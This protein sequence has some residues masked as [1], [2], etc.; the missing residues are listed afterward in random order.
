VN[1]LPKKGFVA[2]TLD[3]LADHDPRLV[4]DPGTAKP[5]LIWSRSDGLSRQIA[6]TRFAGGAWTDFKYVTSGPGD[7]IHPAAGVDSRGTGY[8][9]WVEPSGS[10]SVVF[11]TFDPG[12]GRLFTAPRDLFQELIR[13][14]PPEILSAD[15]P[16]APVGLSP[17]DIL[18]EGGSDVPG[19]PP[20]SSN[21]KSGLP[22]GGPGG[23]ITVTPACSKAAAAVVKERAVW[24][25]VFDGG[26]VI[27]YYRSTIPLGASDDYVNKLL[28]GLLDRHCSESSP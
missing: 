20:G 16:A 6:Y 9:V 23:S 12:T 4:L 7:H 19:I 10:G 15:D 22:P 24:I 14:S 27:K 8:V 11:A 21:K 17:S 3:R 18:P 2:P 26:V 5:F 1:G 13:H 25:G 28:Q